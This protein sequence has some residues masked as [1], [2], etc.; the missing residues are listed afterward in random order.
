MK[1]IRKMLKKNVEKKVEKKLLKKSKKIEKKIGKNCKNNSGKIIYS[2]CQSLMKDGRRKKK[3]EKYFISSC[4]RE[5]KIL[6]YIQR[7]Q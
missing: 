3:I 6:Y 5:L 4:L 7:R 1:N 2:T